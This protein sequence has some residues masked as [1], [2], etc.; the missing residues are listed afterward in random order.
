MVHKRIFPLHRLRTL[1]S[2]ASPVNKLHEPK[3]D[4]LPKHSISLFLE[5]TELEYRGNV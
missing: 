4:V 5:Q 1:R 2:D 3:L